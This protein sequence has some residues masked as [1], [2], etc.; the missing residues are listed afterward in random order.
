[1]VRQ[2]D[3]RNG[4]AIEG[5][6]WGVIAL[7]LNGTRVTLKTKHKQQIEADMKHHQLQTTA[8]DAKQ[9]R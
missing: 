5:S 9:G 6:A 3:N 7:R 1:M 2:T 8:T 4:N